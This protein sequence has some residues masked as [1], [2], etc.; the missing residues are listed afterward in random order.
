M[1]IKKKLTLNVII[2]LVIVC[3]VVATSIVGMGSVKNKLFYLTERST[4]HQIRTLE[5]QR[6]LQAAT[7][8]LIRVSASRSKDEYKTN[9]A[10]AE[11]S[12]SEVKNSQSALESLL[13]GTKTDSY[14]EL[15]K[16]AQELFETVAE[17]LKSEEEAASAHKTISVKL[18]DFSNTLKDLDSKIKALQLNRSAT[19]VTSIED[20]NTISSKLRNI[21]SLRGIVKDIQ[22][23]ALE[24]QKSQDKRAA[25]IARG[26]INSAMNKALLNEYLRASK[27]LE[28]DMKSLEEKLEEMGKLHIALLGQ[29]DAD[30]KTKYDAVN[31][32]VSEKVSSFLLSIEQ[33]VGSAGERFGMETRRQGDVLTQANVATNV[34]S[35]NSELVALGLTLEGFTSRLFIATSA[36]DVGGIGSELG[37]AYETIDSVEK[38]L[39]KALKKLD[40]KDEAKILQNVESALTTIRGMLFA[41]EGVISK[42]NRKLNM[43]E[44]ALQMTSKLQTIV[45]KQ[46]EKGR[47]TV[48]VAQ[49]E[50]EKAIG[51][52]NRMVG[53]SITLIAAISIG[54]VVIGILFGIW[55]YRSISRP[56][57]QLMNVAD[58]VSNGN[59]A[60]VIPKSSSDEIGVVQTSMAKMVGNLKEIVGK[61]TASTSRLASSSE[62]LS[63][64]AIIIDKGSR[65]QTSQVE[66]S[67]TAMDEMS[68]TTLDVAKNAS[69]TSDSAVKMK[70]LAEQGKHAMG[71]TVTE[72][73]KFSDTF[74]QA[75]DKIEAVS[76]QS[77]DISNVVSL[78]REIAEQ[79]NLLA[80]NAAIEA[81]HA[82]DMGRGFAVVADNVRQLAERTAGAT[83]DIAKT[84]QQMQ[85]DVD[86]TVTFVR[87]EK[88][89]VEKVLGQV[90]GTMEKIGGIASNVEQVTSMIQRIAVATDQQS[91]TST[92]VSHSMEGITNITRQLNN[93]IEEI[94]RSSA[95]LSKLA[96]ELNS[97]AGWFKT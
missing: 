19:F 71:V 77:Q 34:L 61:I 97:M 45:M 42:V 85:T 21:E 68:Q 11:K 89:A 60:Y 31:N 14:E 52:V 3:S 1:T 95:D 5:L 49:G 40:A 50:Q 69:A 76:R 39:D 38:R 51:E 33:E 80:L 82:G 41:K 48:T 58:E 10:E 91:S 28:T 43:D 23:S 46:A 66:Q 32:E 30:T 29:A 25:I 87:R 13:G 57:T 24:M 67:A 12:L 78:I 36:K 64:T 22:L 8:D 54:A 56:L 44:K 73:V 93:S 75:A 16:I 88:D 62:E 15:N 2:V 72:L 7:A 37:K 63:A 83:E 9:R 6:T 20:T 81:A 65:E 53:Y 96:T 47:Q 94:K 27:T 79:T 86:E 70:D 4:P 59:L 92:M 90:K 55:A 18:S 35:G 74:R 17:K 26:K 84:M